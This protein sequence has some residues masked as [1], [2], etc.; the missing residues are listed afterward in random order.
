[1]F[2]S[3][4]ANVRNPFILTVTCSTHIPSSPQLPHPPHPPPFPSSTR[5]LELSSVNTIASCESV[6]FTRREYDDLADDDD[7]EDDCEHID[8]I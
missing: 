1:M 3:A 4:C 2:Y 7:E 5:S 8:F 6:T